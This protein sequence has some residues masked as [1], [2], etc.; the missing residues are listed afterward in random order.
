MKPAI[1]LSS[2]PSTWMTAGVVPDAGTAVAIVLSRVFS[3]SASRLASAIAAV[4]KSG[5]SGVSTLAR[6]GTTRLVGSRPVSPTALVTAVVVI[7]GFTTSE[8]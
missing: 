5:A 4:A 7:P 8:R 1:E 6:P 2:S 3:G